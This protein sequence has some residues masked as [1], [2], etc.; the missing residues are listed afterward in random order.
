MTLL[1]DGLKLGELTG[2][3]F[4]T[5]WTGATLGRHILSAMATDDRGATSASTDVSIWVVDENGDLIVEA[6]PDQIISLPNPA[7]LAGTVEIQT[8]VTGGQTNVTWSKLDGPDD[9]QFSDPNA[10]N[11]SVQFSKPGSYT[12]KLQVAYA[13]GTRSDLLKVD[14]LPPLRTGSRRRAQIGAPISG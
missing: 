2:P 7:F 6:G 10:L 11:T 12:L 13:G 14:V 1:A 4:T 9:V 3:P 5:A 8:P